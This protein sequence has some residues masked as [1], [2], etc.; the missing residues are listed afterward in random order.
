MK[1]WSGT[2]IDFYEM[3]VMGCTAVILEWSALILVVRMKSLV[4]NIAFDS[5]A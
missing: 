4:L 2:K 3:V 1:C 5:Y